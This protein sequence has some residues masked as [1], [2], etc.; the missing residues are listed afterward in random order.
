MAYPAAP[1]FPATPDAASGGGGGGG[2]TGG[3]WE[4]VKNIDLTD[5]ETQSAISGTVTLTF[6]GSDDE[7][8]VTRTTVG[9]GTM[10][11]ITPTNG[12]GI[13]FSEESGSGT[14]SASFLI[15]SL[16]SASWDRENAAKYLHAVH[17]VVTNITYPVANTTSFQYIVNR[18]STTAFNSGGARGMRWIDNNDGANEDFRLRLN[19]STGS[20]LGT[21]TIA[22][23]KVI[24]FLIWMGDVIGVQHTSGT[25][26]PTPAPGA[27]TT[28]TVGTGSISMG[29]T[30]PLYV[31][32]GLRVL[33]GVLR[34]TQTVTRIL[35]QRYK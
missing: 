31:S 33:A 12:T 11:S 26:P 18:G 32:N 30:T 8:S 21:Q 5:V 24:T 22:T 14:A 10:A 9:S 29:D 1:S 3:E 13:V 27:A 25:T 4:T 15:S 16:F 34:G 17:L 7:L 28:Y 6:A 20:S 23:S 19:G 35:V 2:S